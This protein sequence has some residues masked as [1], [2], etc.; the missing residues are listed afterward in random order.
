M[1]E[2]LDHIQLAIPSGGEAAGRA[3]WVDL[4]GL[5]EIEKPAELMSRGGLW[6]ALGGAELHLGVEAQFT[7]AKKAHPGFRTLDTKALA[8][9]LSNNGTVINWD[10]TITA[11]KRF[12]CEDPFGNR[13]EFLED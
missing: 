11:R 1:I 13:L 10:D 6:L 9:R 12:F 3:F 7:P 2:G 4:V 8:D 5:T